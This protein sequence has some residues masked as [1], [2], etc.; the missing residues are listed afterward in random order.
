[1]RCWRVVPC[2]VG[3][4]LFFACIAVK[5]I[6][7][8]WT[9][10][11]PALIRVYAYLASCRFPFASQLPWNG[12]TRDGVPMV[13][14][15][16]KSESAQLRRIQLCTVGHL[17][18]PVRR[19]P[20]IAFP[21]IESAGVHQRSGQFSC[22]LNSHEHPGIRGRSFCSSCPFTV[23]RATAAGRRAHARRVIAGPAAR[24]WRRQPASG[25]ARGRTGASGLREEP[26][27]SE[28]TG[29]RRDGRC[30]GGGPRTGKSGACR[31]FR[32]PAVAGGASRSAW[33]V[34]PVR[35]VPRLPHRAGLPG[36]RRT[37]A[38]ARIRI[39]EQRKG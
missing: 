13:R 20:G 32:M 15:S 21:G 7:H 26:A 31:H 14:S 36:R 12:L 5:L 23:G 22:P 27:R 6:M 9:A 8:F 11:G 30:S 2:R 38:Q 10:P 35:G 1:M 19:R 34:D 25:R 4:S 3:G 29:R 33:P 37:R 24:L 18:A 28:T 16:P 17:R 39:S